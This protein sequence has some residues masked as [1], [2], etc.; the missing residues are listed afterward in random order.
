[1]RDEHS[2]IRRHLNDHLTS[3]QIV[4]VTDRATK[5][6]LL[7]R[8]SI[9]Q[10]VRDLPSAAQRI[11]L[12]FREL[13][14]H[15]SGARAVHCE[16]HLP[17]E[18]YLD[19]DLADLTQART[20][21]TESQIFWKL[22]LELALNSLL[23]HPLPVEV[24]DLLSFGDIVSLREPLRESSFMRR[25]DELIAAAIDGVQ[26][27]ELLFDPHQLGQVQN[28]LEKSFR[29]VF[30][31]ELRPFLKRKVRNVSAL[32][33]SS[34]SVGLGLLGLVPGVGG[35]FGLA[36]LGK[37]MYALV[38]NLTHAFTSRKAAEDIATYAEAK[39][40]MLHKLIKR[41]RLSDK[42]TMF[43]MVDLLTTTIT[44]RMKL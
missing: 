32:T 16:S 23:R 37:D 3:T 25:Y 24:L 9:D 30:E 1:L 38:T 40:I 36:S 12:A 15:V 41:S 17:Q 18:D 27:N 19:Y 26:N 13:L 21:L 20:R 39:R 6:P 33:D 11:V 8:N 34:T 29:A 14:Y 10:A 42:T 35:L 44:E 31:E 5:T 7:T 2:L 4:L 28:D 22:F 43:D